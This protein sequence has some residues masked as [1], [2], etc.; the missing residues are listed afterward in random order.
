MFYIAVLRKN[1]FFPTIKTVK[2]VAVNP[3]E[4]PWFVPR[5]RAS[6]SRRLDY[7]LSYAQMLVTL[8]TL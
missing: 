4:N 2:T 6:Y 8:F 3:V 1:H 5:N 7:A